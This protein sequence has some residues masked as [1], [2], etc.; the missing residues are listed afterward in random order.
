MKSGSFMELSYKLIK[1]LIRCIILDK[2][3]GCYLVERFILAY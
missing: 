3:K 2:M 1:K